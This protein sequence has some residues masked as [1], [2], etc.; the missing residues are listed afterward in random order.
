MTNTDKASRL[1]F[2]QGYTNN[3]PELFKL[4]KNKRQLFDKLS[5]LTSWVLQIRF[6]SAA[7]CS[8][9]AHVDVDADGGQQRNFL[10][11]GCR[12]QAGSLG[13]KAGR[14]RVAPVSC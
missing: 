9:N 11:P 2:T 6:D 12:L 13:D 8:S 14:P 5:K 7:P 10:G 3:D 4:P 1:P